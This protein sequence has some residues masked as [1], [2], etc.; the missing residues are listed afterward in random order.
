MSEEQRVL[1]TR[2]PRRAYAIGAAVAVLVTV[3]SSV[4]AY[5]QYAFDPRPSLLALALTGVL[6]GMAGTVLLAFRASFPFQTMQGRRPHLPPREPPV[7]L[8]VRARFVALVATAG[9]SLLAIV[10]L[11]LRSCG[12]WPSATLR[13][14]AWRRGVR[15]LLPDGTPLRPTDPAPGS[16][17][18]VVP[19]SS[20]DDANSY[21]VLVRLRGSGEVRAFSRIC[22]HAGCAVCIFRREQSELECPCHHSV[23]DAADGG[24]IVSGPASKPL[25]E[26]PLSVDAD[27]YLVAEG[28]FDGPV[29]PLSG[30]S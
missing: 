3:G 24:R 15:L 12:T 16:A 13:A 2:P 28:D 10:L 23:F 1:E 29:G 7:D 9:A 11:P 27:G 30:V 18:A 22:T 6:W 25:P 21:A 17:T 26:L 14:T 8:G 4:W 5:L 19:A 20:P